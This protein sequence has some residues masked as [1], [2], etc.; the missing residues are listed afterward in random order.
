MQLQGKA[1]IVTGANRGF[2]RHL[3]QQLRDRGVTVYAAARDPKTVDLAGVT[4]LRLDITDPASIAAAVEAVQ[5]VSILVN[6]A[7][8][9]TGATLIAGDLGHIRHEFETN[10]FGTLL[11]TRAFAPLLAEHSESYVLN[12]LSAFSWFN[13]PAVGGYSASKAAQWSLTDGLRQDLAGQGIRVGGLYVGLM[14]TDLTATIDAPK[15]DPARVAQLAVDGIETGA[16][17]ILADAQSTAIRAGLSGGVAA[18]YPQL[19]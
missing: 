11:V 17:E 1:A 6:N 4:P 16:F 12:V 19:G 8:V 15:E 5:D 3:A 10:F 18:L 7:G 14:D 13:V 2:G 9:A